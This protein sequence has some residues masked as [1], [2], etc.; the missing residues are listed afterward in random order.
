MSDGFEFTDR[1]G[2]LFAEGQSASYEADEVYIGTITGVPGDFWFHYEDPEA[3]NIER[4]KITATIAHNFKIVEAPETAPAEETDEQSKKEETAETQLHNELA[5]V[6][7]RAVLESALSTHQ[8]IGVL[9]GIKTDLL[10]TKY[11]LTP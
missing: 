9:E 6:I 8:I 10:I 2:S 5:V 1:N 7:N 3:G 4:I 11:R